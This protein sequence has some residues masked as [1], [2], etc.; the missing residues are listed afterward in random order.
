M[1]IQTGKGGTIPVMVVIAIWSLSIGINLP[2]LAVTPI[3]GDLHS[4]FNKVSDFQVQLLTVLPNLVI[5]PFV[6]LSGRLSMTPHKI[7]VIAAGVII[8]VVSGILYLFSKTLDDLIWISCLLGAGCGLMLPFTTGLI[9]DVF[10]GKYK[11][12]QM[13][14]VSAI[15]NIALVVATFI[16]GFLANVNWHLPFLVYILP[17]ISLILLPWFNKIPKSDMNLDEDGNPVTQPAAAPAASGVATAAP[18]TAQATT[19]PATEPVAPKE[20]DADFSTANQKIV[21]GFYLGRTIWTLLAYF[22]FV[23]AT[24]VPAYYLPNLHGIS[25]EKASIITSAI[26]FAMFIIGISLNNVLRV[27]KAFSFI[28][29]GGLL[30]GGFIMFS[31][32]HAEGWFIVAAALVGFGQGMA[33]PIFFDKATEICVNTSH[34]TLSMAYLQVANYIAI[35]IV[36][37][38]VGFFAL[39]FKVDKAEATTHFPFI[40]NMIFMAIVFFFI[41]IRYKHFTF[42]IHKQYYS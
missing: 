29:S 40:L 31:F 10:A 15:G 3:E 33:Q 19:A 7:P 5:I 25:A 13:G 18:A 11:L 26:Y 6:L 8:Y 24:S 32:V 12:K 41:I 38:I 21:G 22:F 23:Y 4:I 39:I 14:I 35:A 34:A 9:A 37:V 27:F 17:V 2:G 28:V 30:L 16:V 42:G 36:P 20:D 1:Q